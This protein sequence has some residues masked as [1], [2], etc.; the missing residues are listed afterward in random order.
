MWPPRSPCRN[1]TE[2]KLSSWTRGNQTIS[3]HSFKYKKMQTLYQSRTELSNQILISF[4]MQGKQT[5]SYLANA[6]GWRTEK[7]ARESEGH[8]QR[9]KGIVGG[10]SDALSA[11]HCYC[12]SVTA[13]S[14]GCQDR[15][16]VS[17][18]L[19]PLHWNDLEEIQ[20]WGAGHGRTDL[21]SKSF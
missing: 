1:N 14:Q 21:Q 16:G 15:A 19:Q 10:C 11:V 6:L 17:K 5:D 18:R 4:R 13:G 2:L 20:S 7:K 3:R 12:A 9:K 8:G